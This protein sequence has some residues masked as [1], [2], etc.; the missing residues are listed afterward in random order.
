MFDNNKTKFKFFNAKPIY[1][2]K[3][4]PHLVCLNFSSYIIGAFCLQWWREET[5]IWWS[6]GTENNSRPKAS[7]FP[8]N[9]I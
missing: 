1:S 9:L 8:T 5:K 6:S 4:Q 2:L 3:V 7:G